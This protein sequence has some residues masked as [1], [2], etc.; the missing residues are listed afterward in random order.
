MRANLVPSDPNNGVPAQYQPGY[1]LDLPNDQIRG[2]AQLQDK[3][4]TVAWEDTGE[5]GVYD[6]ALTTHDNKTVR[7]SYAYNV[8]ADVVAS[9]LVGWTIDRTLGHDT[10]IVAL[11]LVVVPTTLA[12]VAWPGLGAHTRM[13]SMR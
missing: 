2:Q 13:D 9:P 4:L 1:T 8:N 7:R 5:A 11:G 10:A 12:F 3:L 6:L